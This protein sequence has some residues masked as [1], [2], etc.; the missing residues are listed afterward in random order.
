[1]RLRM[2]VLAAA[3]AA[4][5]LA[6]ARPPLRDVAEIDQG[7]LA[8]GIADAIRKECDEI[9]PRMFR[10]L[11]YIG[12]LERRA[13]TLGYTEDEI[14]DYVNSKA[15]KAR[16]RRLGKAYV[17]QQ[18]ARLSDPASMCALGRRE[19]ARGSPIGAL[20]KEK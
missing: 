7:L 14:D 1:M 16:M 11:S 13:R 3:L 9:A 5:A 4:P 15:E 19:I 17:S 2:L 6:E 8:V 12:Q 20:L 18:G 10:A